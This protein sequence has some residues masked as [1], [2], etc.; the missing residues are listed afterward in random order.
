M[1][2]LVIPLA[3]RLPFSSLYWKALAT[4]NCSLFVPD[5]CST[6]YHFTCAA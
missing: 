6:A 4:S 2:L 1:V 3:T 5:G